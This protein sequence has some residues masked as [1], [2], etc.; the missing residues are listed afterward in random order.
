MK[1]VVEAIIDQYQLLIE[2]NDVWKSLYG[3]GGKILHEGYAQRI[4]LRS[5]GYIL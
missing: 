3:P 5:C 2:V 1:K 4:F